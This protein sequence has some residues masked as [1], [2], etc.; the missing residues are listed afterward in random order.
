MSIYFFPFY[1]Q[2]ACENYIPGPNIER[3]LFHVVIFCYCMVDTVTI[4]TYLF[5]SMNDESDSYHSITDG[6]VAR[7]PICSFFFRGTA[8]LT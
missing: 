5:L 2:H 8:P 1:R 6:E 4:K 3:T 7:S